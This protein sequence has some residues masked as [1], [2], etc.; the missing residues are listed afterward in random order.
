[1]R[2]TALGPLLALIAA[3]AVEQIQHRI[4]ILFGITG[5]RVN[6]HPAFCADGLRIVIDPFEFAAL[7]SLVRFVEALWRIRKG[8]F[9]VWLQLDWA[10]KSATAAPFGRVGGTRTR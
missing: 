7:D 1:M 5:R 8:R 10:A 3:N 6:L 4:F 9:V 2:N